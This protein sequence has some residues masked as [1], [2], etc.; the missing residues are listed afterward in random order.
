M[1]GVPPPADGKLVEAA[2]LPWIPLGTLLVRAGLLTPHQLENAL[3]DK[4]ASGRRLGEIVVDLGWVTPRALARALA[5]QYGLEFLDLAEVEVDGRIASRLPE[6]LA[7]RY[8][9]LPVKALGEKLLL[10]AVSDPTNVVVSDDL[11]LALG[12]NLQFAVVA[13]PDLERAF[14]RHYRTEI[15]ISESDVELSIVQDEDL[16]NLEEAAGAPTI[17]LVNSLLHRAIEDGASDLH[18]E[19]QAREM[20]VRAR[21]DGVMRSVVSIPRHMQASVVSRL[22]I[23]GDLDIAERRMPQDGR[24]SVGFGGQP[25]D[26][27]MAVLPSTHGEQVVLRIFHRGLE[28]FSLGDLGLTGRTKSD[29]DH[30][31]R[32][33]YGLIICSG[34]TGSGKTTTLYGALDALNTD[35]R[36][37]QTIEDPVEYQIPGIVQVE[38]NQKSGLT[39][40]RGL[41][42]LL[43]SD[44]DVLL[45]GEIRDEETARIA[46]TAAMTGHLVLSSLHAHSA[47][48]SIARLRDLGVEPGLL[49]TS[50][51]C[52]IGQRLVRRLCRSCRQPFTPSAEERQELALA[53]SGEEV[54]LYRAGGCLECSETG[55]AGRTALYET[56]PVEGKLRRLIDASTEEIFAAAVAQGMTT[57]RADGIRRCLDGTT[58]IDELR[59]VTGDRLG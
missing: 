51:N 43:R 1:T 14:N 29:L 21:V 40:A 33:P 50:L 20:L 54:V 16:Q 35:G 53:A 48:S 28:R 38:V 46:S 7:R 8:E 4:E 59:R 13:R 47:S 34:P 9:A 44:P 49:A 15:T 55:Y 19:P 25:I 58:S 42:A 52:I 31:L 41:R 56:M 32:Q 10:V 57:L 2:Q 45:V 23:M 11:R 37:L 24:V 17:N 6:T 36:V 22:K 12:A 39:F 18:F 5:E 27:R 3:A 30:A 26:I